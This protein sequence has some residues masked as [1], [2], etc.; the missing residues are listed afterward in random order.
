MPKEDASLMN[1]IN[2]LSMAQLESFTKVDFVL[3]LARGKNDSP[4]NGGS[5]FC[6]VKTLKKGLYAVIRDWEIPYRLNYRIY[7]G[8]TKKAGAS[9]SGVSFSGIEYFGTR[10]AVVEKMV[11][12]FLEKAL[13][14]GL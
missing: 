13:H 8:T 4:L 6:G 9:F 14:Q 12:E 1:I 2:E 5:V 10:N 3:P 7:L 11:K